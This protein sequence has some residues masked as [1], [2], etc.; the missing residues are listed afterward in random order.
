MPSGSK[1]GEHRGGRAKGT[2]N[3]ATQQKAEATKRLKEAAA[4]IAKETGASPR[5]AEAAVVAAI[6]LPVKKGLKEQFE[7]EVLPTVK[8]LMA[9]HQAQCMVKQEDGTILLRVNSDYEMFQYWLSV[10][11]AIGTKLLPYNYPTI[12]AVEAH[13]PVR[14]P[15]PVTKDGNVIQMGDPI[16]AARIYAQLMRRPRQLALPGP[17]ADK[18]VG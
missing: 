7:D 16:R 18:K 1:P 4:R 12:K 8:N 14:E 2:Q 9:Y 5:V 6:T 3:V 13:E 11:S 15:V 10:W 17:K